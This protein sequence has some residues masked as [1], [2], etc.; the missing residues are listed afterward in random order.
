LFEIVNE[1]VP[2]EFEIYTV[3]FNNDRV[4]DY[5]I[6]FMRKNLKDEHLHIIVDNSSDN[7]ISEKIRKICIEQDT[8]YIRLPENN[9]FTSQS[10]ALALNYICKNIVEKRGCKYF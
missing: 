9:L 5:Q 3:A 2:H 7:E 6:K 4:I 10:H 8:M 1:K